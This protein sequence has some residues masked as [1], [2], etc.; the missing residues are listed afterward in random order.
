M[1]TVAG[2]FAP[3]QQLYQEWVPV[4][5]AE[6]KELP[7]YMKDFRCVRRWY[8]AR[9]RRKCSKNGRQYGEQNVR[10]FQMENEGF[11]VCAVAG[12]FV[13]S[14]KWYQE[15][16]QYGEQNVSGFQMEI[17]DFRCVRLLGV[18]SHRRKGTKSG[19][20]YEEQNVR[21]SYGKLRISGVY[22]CWTFCPITAIVPRV[23]PS[24]AS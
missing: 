13:P 19:P 18:L 5:R 1:C 7:T 9:N 11:Q 16:A 23:G 14:Q 6:C 17:K 21:N 24:V 3:S 22:G 10:N 20:H 12:I 15:W 4:W 8:F 2:H